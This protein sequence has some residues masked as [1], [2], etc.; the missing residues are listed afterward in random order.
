MPSVTVRDFATEVKLPVDALLT[1]LQEAGIKVE[2]ADSTL[3]DADK[4][5]LLQHIR[6]KREKQ[7]AG[8]A[9]SGRMGLK[10]KTTTE[11]KLGGGRGAGA[12]TVSVEVRKRRTFEKPPAEDPRAA[13]A[14]EEAR[15]AEEQAEADR[16]R[17]EV[18]A[19]EAAERER[20]ERE[21]AEREEADRQ[22]AEA[23]AEADAR[24]AEAQAQ[25]AAEP[26]PAPDAAPEGASE[27]ADT[28]EAHAP[29][30]EA[31]ES[32]APEI[33]AEDAVS[34]PAEPAAAAPKK[35]EIIDSGRRAASAL[36]QRAAENLRRAAEMRAAQPEQPQT[37]APARPAAGAKADKGSRKE[38]HV[39]AG[40]SGRR[41]KKSGRRQR[42]QVD[43]RHGFEKPTAPV[44][45]D[46]AVPE[47]IGVGD[48]AAAMA[49]KTGDLIKTLMRMGVMA[50]IN[51]T[52][53][54]DTAVLVVEEMGHRPRPV[55]EQ[56]EEE[57]LVAAATAGGDED[58]QEAARAP[59]VTVM[60]HVDH[61]KTSL[62]D[63]IRKSR[64]ASG[65]AG[66]ITQ[67][68]GAYNV[69]TPRGSITFLDTPGHAAFTRMRARGAQVTDI[70][71]LII[72]ADDGVM[73][74][75]REAIQHARAA[76]VPMVVAITK[77]DKED[78]D[79]DKIKSEL[80]KE[81][82]V[83][84]DWGG[85]IQCVA[86][87]SHTGA[88]VEELLDSVVLQAELLELKAV[89]DDVARGAI[90]ES[91]VEKGRGPTATVLVRNGTLK[92]GDV[93]IAGPYFGRVRAMFDD[94]GAPCKS[95]G[96]STPVQVLGLSG[97]PDAGE[98]VMSVTD[99]R[100]ARELAE[101]REKKLREQKLAQSQA[102]RLDRAFERMGSDEHKQLNIMIRGDVQGSVEALSEALT[103]LP[104]EEVKVNIVAAA[105]GGISESDV[106][107]AVASEAIIIGFNTRADGKAR[108]RIQATG[109]DVRYYS[110]I[111][112]VIDDISDAIS[113]LLGTELREK[114]VGTAEVRDVFRSSAF[115]AVAGCLVVDGEV[116]RGLPIRV[117]RDQVVIYEG[118]LESLRRHKDDAQKVEAGTECGIAVKNYNDVKVGDQ[119]ECYD[120]EEVRRKVSAEQSGG[121]RG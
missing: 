48:L 112:D 86:V 24:A 43:N 110:I 90:I 57:A 38:L 49:V 76:G 6:A 27:T 96:P 120:R 99:E 105:V 92:Q 22:A 106:D 32:E 119:I 114:I 50:T 21:Q 7:S 104:S 89:V 68:I 77:I 102:V 71:I 74:Q 70:V 88:G 53:D 98:E 73:P 58:R 10:R 14:A 35:D 108:Q 72:A 81:E 75:T 56:A 79:V 55:S 109:V 15:K 63:Y 16:Q 117:L 37:P 95:A 121:R 45:R 29:E 67:H 84:E 111:Y 107:L 40:K 66:G 17:Q 9:A 113:G 33:K 20:A 82:V 4:A 8:Q 52:L 78:A 51:Q 19:Q 94:S 13:A 36:R 26:E 64:V 83:V 41:E 80:T 87:S 101:L 5:A 69:S 11:L 34:K 46:V 18:E 91:S 116:R 42:V 54:Q 59:I 1:Q 100:A 31:P 12:R 44:V 62:L 28:Q 30:S 93:I 39:K 3:S 65:E 2:N 115:G 85:D 25:E 97:A 103:K 118:E 60:G 47:M 23:Q 61:G